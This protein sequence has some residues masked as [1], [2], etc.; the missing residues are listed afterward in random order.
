MIMRRIKPTTSSLRLQR[1][2]RSIVRDVWIVAGAIMIVLLQ[3]PAFAPAA[4][5]IFLL[6]MFGIFMF[7][8]ERNG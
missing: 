6:A 1:K 2:R 3:N 5:V 8:D 7:L 4:I